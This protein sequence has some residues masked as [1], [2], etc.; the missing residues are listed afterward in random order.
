MVSVWKGLLAR[1]IVVLTAVALLPAA[2][3][4]SA[5]PDPGGTPLWVARYN[6]PGNGARSG[7]GQDRARGHLFPP[8]PRDSHKADV[9]GM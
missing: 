8:C 5:S 4:V 9:E 6:G 1:T 2:Q 3:A 7:G